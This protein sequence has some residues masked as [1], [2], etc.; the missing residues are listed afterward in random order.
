MPYAAVAREP[1]DGPIAQAIAAALAGVYRAQALAALN[2]AGVPALS[3]HRTADLFNDPQV[4]ANELLA[5]LHHSRWGGVV[6]TGTL[7]KFSAMPSK[8]ERA[9]P[10]LGEH[11]DELL[12]RHLGYDQERIASLR[13]GGIVK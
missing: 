9:A 6:Q 3:T 1:E 2:A 5:E 7:A 8:V 13:R 11:T 4:S 10:L 12:A